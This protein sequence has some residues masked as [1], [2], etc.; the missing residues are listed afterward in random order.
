M[1][2]SRKGDISSGQ[3]PPCKD[4]L[5]QQ[6]NRANYQAAIWRRSLQNSPEIPSPTNGHGWNVV[7][8]KLGICWLTGAPAP[9]VVLEL[10]SC[11][12]PRRCNE[13]CPCVV[14][15]FSCTPACKLLDCDNMQ[16][17]DELIEVNKSSL[18]FSFSSY[19][20]EDVPPVSVFQFVMSAFRSDSDV[21]VDTLT[22][23][24]HSARRI[25]PFDRK[26]NDKTPLIS[27]QRN[28]FLRKFGIGSFDKTSSESNM[29]N[30]EDSDSV[31][32]LDTF[33]G[34]F[35]PVCL[36]MFSVLLFLRVGFCVG[37]A[38]V[39]QALLM[40]IIAYGIILSTVFSVCAISTN[41]AVEGGGAYFMISRTLGPEFGG[42]IGSLFFLAN[43]F[44]SALYITGCVEGLIN[45]FGPG[46]MYADF[47]SNGTHWQF[48][49]ATC[50]N[51]LNLLICLVGASLFAR[52]NIVI[53]GIV[54]I[55]IISCMLSF[56]I[57]NKYTEV[58]IPEENHHVA[59]RTAPYTGFVSSTFLDNLYCKFDFNSI[60]ISSA[61]F[62]NG[63]FM[64]A[65]HYS[66]DYNTGAHADFAR[67]FGVVFSGVTGIMAGANM[68]G[69]LK[70]PSKSIPLGTMLAVISTFVTYIIIIFLMAGTTSGALLR[71]NYL[72]L[73]Y[74]NV[75]SPL[76][77]VGIISASLS[78]SLS[79]IIG[80]SR[81]LQAVAKD[82]LFGI[83][84]SPIVKGTR[85]GNP[86]A[87]VVLSWLFVQLVLLIGSYNKIAQM[88]SVFFLISYAAVNLAC[89][90]LEL[91]SA[92]NFRPMFK[93]FSWHTATVGLIGCLS[94]MFLISPIYAAI[95]IIL[96]LILVIVLHLIPMPA[97]WGSIS[98]ALI[99]H[100]VR[101]YLLM[102]DS[103][104]DHIR[105]WRPQ[106]LLMV[107]NPRTCLP[108]ISFINDIK[109]GGL[110]IIGHVKLGCIA[111]HE[112]DP[113]MEENPVW[114]NLIDKMKIKAFTELTL[115]KSVQD[116]MHQLVRL[117]GLGAMKP[118]TI[119]LGFYDD[120][121]PID[122]FS[123]E[124]YLCISES[125]ASN[126][127]SSRFYI[128]EES[129]SG[130]EN[131]S[132]SESFPEP[133]ISRLNNFRSD[134]SLTDKDYVEMVKDSIKMRKNVCLARHFHLLNKKAFKKKVSCSVDVWPMNFFNPNHKDS[135]DN[136]WMFMLQLSCIL[137]MVPFWQ[138]RANM[139][140]FMCVHPQA[141][142][143]SQRMEVWK[144][145][146][147]MLRVDATIVIVHWSHEN[148]NMEQLES[149]ESN[150]D[151]NLPPPP[152][153]DLTNEYIKDVNSLIKSH[154]TNTAISFLYLPIP[155]KSQ[156]EN[157]LYLQHL[158]G[159]TLNLPP[160]FLVHGNSPVTSTTL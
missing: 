24:S 117:S 103:R 151:C 31:R 95:S 77:A 138:K 21:S 4:A 60:I 54:V 66:V 116:G 9:D 81:V 159:M 99:F 115:A 94:M 129:I 134:R 62:T 50:I 90:G 79:N 64:F 82:N 48:L 96:C 40:F 36:S 78:A 89:L 75:F 59:F 137:Y 122:F 143:V 126:T 8:R 139:R 111:D 93:Y 76:V 104:K 47:L 27:Q 142:D 130:V 149:D 72:V 155:P 86:I 158:D 157:S 98:Q 154:S 120:T 25:N 83:L 124:E 113:T 58:L 34:V 13:N 10:M 30:T 57:K 152:I 20:K 133:E 5:K 160:T 29:N 84:L 1:F 128:N 108:L 6:T 141:T 42:S 61:I 101:K 37:F 26:R 91:A 109:K 105:F 69:E 19:K 127:S 135:F 23:S 56:L 147:D 74:I 114:L 100:Q 12:C 39:L 53:F 110:Y 55:S 148:P 88:T 131:R 41:G 51:F 146:L 18:V 46:G 44:S 17:E 65:A 150:V 118:N 2:R 112:S 123:K 119:I 45:N 97:D 87:A 70:N 145:W 3:L 73:Q 106:M 28:R 49:Y 7:E 15:G 14:N 121:A 107:A 52:T 156:E 71:N 153:T 67:V 125:S 16:E 32:N 43:I 22:S 92:P 33:S 140:V 136:T 63:C 38:G 144:Q 35:T 68:S 132:N 102:L 11:K 80:A 85:N